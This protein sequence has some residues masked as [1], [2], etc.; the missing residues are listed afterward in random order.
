MNIRSL[1]DFDRN[2]SQINREERNLA[3]LLYYAL[4]QNNNT[5]RFL[6]LIGCPGECD[7]ADFGIYFEYSFLRD[8][9]HNIDKEYDRDR[10]NELKRRAI[11]KLLEPANADDLRSNSTLEFN[12]YFGCVPRPS[13]KFIQSPSKWSI[14]GN[15]REGVKG[16]SQ[17]IDDNDLFEKVCKFK[18]AFNIKPDIVIH[19]SR[20]SAVCIEAKL[21]SGEG[22]YPS[23]SSEEAVCARR[24]LCRKITQTELQRYM[25][26][27]LLGLKTE[28]V[29][30][31]N[32][33]N[34]G[35]ESHTTL[36]WRGVFNSFDTSGFH[37]FILEWINSYSE[38]R[39][40]G[41]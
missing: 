5:Q 12:K 18:W 28:F 23:R 1:L 22:H 13:A 32:N 30:L 17:T 24:G 2:Y 16:F 7:G 40:E 9:W 27:Q 20:G 3:A 38:S 26:V 41:V 39:Q 35:S 8:L 21:E 14:M 4:F 15:P 19:K 6:S 29:L 31:V 34:R 11:L 10:G 36:T 33:P 37:P 25:M